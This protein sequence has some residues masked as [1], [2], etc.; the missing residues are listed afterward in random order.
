MFRALIQ[1]ILSTIAL[2]TCAKLIEGFYVND[3]QS[4]L[5][6]ACAIG[7]LNAMLGFLLKIVNF[8]FAVIS[9]GVF[10]LAINTASIMLA[11]EFVTGF[12][13]Y[14]WMP[15]FWTAVVLALLGMAIRLIMQEG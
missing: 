10:L 1:W 6:A 8:P 4:A 14:G 9:F 2:M 12:V 15:A 5:L 13:V 7:V 3:L 11:S